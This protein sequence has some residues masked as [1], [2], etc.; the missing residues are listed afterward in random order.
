MINDLLQTDDN[1]ILSNRHI[2]LLD[3]I[4]KQNYK[5]CSPSDFEKLFLNW[6]STVLSDEREEW[7][8]NRAES[9]HVLYRLEMKSDA[10]KRAKCRDNKYASF[11][12]HFK[13]VQKNKFL[14][15][16]KAG[17]Q[18]KANYFA[19]WFLANEAQDI[20]IP[21]VEANKINKLTQLAQANNREFKKL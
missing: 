15:F 19:S 17:K 2:R 1:Y 8:Q 4:F 20:D 14:E 18:L 7:E 21:Y 16:R 11:R 9:A 13:E 12:E 3:I 10:I 5:Q 6:A